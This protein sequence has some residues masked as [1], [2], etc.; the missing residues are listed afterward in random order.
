MCACVTVKHAMVGLMH[1]T[2]QKIAAQI[3]AHSSNIMEQT[4]KCNIQTDNDKSKSKKAPKL[5]T[6]TI[7][8]SN[9]LQHKIKSANNSQPTFIKEQQV[10]TL[11]FNWIK[12]CNSTCPGQIKRAKS[13]HSTVS[14]HAKS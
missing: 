4:F 9:N 5:K 11:Y 3:I 8:T 6:Y 7:N 1:K 2:I 12:E 10:H 14:A 13:A